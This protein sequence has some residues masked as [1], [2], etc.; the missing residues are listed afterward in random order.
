LIDSTILKVVSN[1]AWISEMTLGLLLLWRRI[2]PLAVVFGFFT[3]FVIDL[4]AVEV[5]FGIL[6]VSMLFLFCR[7]DINRRLLPV[8]IVL[9]TYLVAARLGWVPG[10]PWM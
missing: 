9:L 10:L 1:A 6:M 2:W 5:I 4:I 7:W 8:Y 3:V